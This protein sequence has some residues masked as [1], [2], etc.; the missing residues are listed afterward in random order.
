MLPSQH[1]TIRFRIPTVDD[2]SDVC[3][4]VR[5]CPPLEFNPPYAYLL[6]CSHFADTSVVCDSDDR[7]G[8]FTGAYRLP[9][10]PDTLF[11]WQIAVSG[12]L[13]GSGIGQLMLSS[14]LAR[15]ALRD[16]RY[17]EATVTPSNSASRRLFTSFAERRGC[18]IVLSAG[19]RADDFPGGNHEA[20]QL[21]RI[22]PL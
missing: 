18:P 13:R 21:F 6:L 10:R 12:D 7:L 1:R 20:E 14:I 11:V 22:G 8:G 15:E 3:G 2:A 16:V 17:L 19:F 9:R 5:N 4:L